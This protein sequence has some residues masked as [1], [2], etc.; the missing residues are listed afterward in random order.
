L[1]EA[2]SNGCDII[3][4]DLEYVRTVVKPS[5]FFNPMSSES[6]LEAVTRALNEDLAPSELRVTDEID[7]LVALLNK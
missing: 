7:A 4:S 5:A 1:I 3:A 6:I 2:L